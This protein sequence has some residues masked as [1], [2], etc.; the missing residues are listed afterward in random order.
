MLEY[1]FFAKGHHNVTSLH[2]TTFELTM[3]KE[4]GIKADCIVGVSSKVKLKD[5]PQKLRKAIKKENS[6]IK[7]QLKTVNAFDEIIGYGHPELSLDHPTDM[8]CRKSN[9]KCSR[10]LMINSN[11]AAIDL[12]REL[13]VDLNEGKDLKVKIIVYPSRL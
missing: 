11:K 12:K 5:F 10:T 9:F 7:L 6:V 1:I 3:D 4:I 13:I 8:V 2:K